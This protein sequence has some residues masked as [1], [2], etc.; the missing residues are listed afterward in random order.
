MD[1]N[2]LPSLSALRAFEAAARLS[3]FSKAAAE[4]NVTH[5]AIAQHVRALEAEFATSLITR[6]G[7]GVVATDE[8]RD[9]ATA[10]QTGFLT[11]AE[12]VET[13]RST[14]AQRPL[15]IST[16]PSFATNW[17]MPRIGDFW[18]LHPDI[19]LNINPSADLV[20]LRADGFDLGI[21]FGR[22]GW[23]GV[24]SEL[25]TDGNFWV[26]ANP[27]LIADRD[28]TCV[29]EL[30][31]LTWLAEDFLKERFGLLE[32]EGV[33]PATL[34]IKL[35]HTSALV[36]SGIRSGLGI[37]IMPRSLVERDVTAGNLVKICTLSQEGFG[38]H[39]ITLPDRAPKGLRELTKWLRS[40]ARTA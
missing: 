33:D 39:M 36:D 1:W 2:R 28:A 26:V 35:L 4:L 12:G 30:T 29:A 3:S 27:S 13:L 32:N 15:N 24:T 22:G 25:L 37:G 14:R 34:N 38:Y 19:A 31:D 21:R 8:G 16:T 17:L 10:L 23:P 40:Q 18:A 6:Q 20:D 11:I 7:R 9:L 5:A